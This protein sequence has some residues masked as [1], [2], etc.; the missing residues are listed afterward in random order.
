MFLGWK[1]I[2]GLE[3]EK[4]RNFKDFEQFSSRTTTRI[5]QKDQDMSAKVAPVSAP[6]LFTIAAKVGL[7]PVQRKG[8][9]KFYAPDRTSGPSIQVWLDKEGKISTQID[10]VNHVSPHAIV[11]KHASR[12]NWYK[13]VAQ[14][15]DLTVDMKQVLNAFYQVAKEVRL[16][17]ASRPAS[18]I[19]SPPASPQP[20]MQDAAGI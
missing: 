5:T 9:V 13:T 17:G 19:A 10:I 15:L 18:P 1:I 2:K 6:T 20:E 7:S 8:Y 3:K 11:H 16:S 12:A 4:F 14:Q